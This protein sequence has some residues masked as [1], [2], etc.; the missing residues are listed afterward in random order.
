[1]ESRGTSNYARFLTF[2]P[3]KVTP[4]TSVLSW[5][6]LS[7]S[8][9]ASP[10]QGHGEDI[11]LCQHSGLRFHR[12]GPWKSRWMSSDSWATQDGVSRRYF[13]VIALDSTRT[14]DTNIRQSLSDSMTPLMTTAW[15]RAGWTRLW[16]ISLIT[17]VTVLVILCWRK[18][19]N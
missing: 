16:L 9:Q 3:W 18:R 6:P 5:G 11:D 7:R 17:R 8:R 12:S 19:R 13:C 2:V 14:T 15:E 1:M 10:R 4:A